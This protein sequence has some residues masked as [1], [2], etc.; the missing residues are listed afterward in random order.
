MRIA[1]IG[2]SEIVYD[3]G[4]LLLQ[5][6]HEIAL[7][8]T[9]KESPEYTRTAD[10]FRQLAERCGAM[11]IRTARIG[12]AVDRIRNLGPIDLAVSTNY[13]TLVP[14]DVIGCF[15]LGILNAHAGDLP[16][17][18]GNA[19]LAW[20]IL[21]GEVRVGLCVHYMDRELDAGDILARDYHPI[22]Q[23][24]SITELWDWTF[25]RTAELFVEAVERL[26][27]DPTFV[28]A[29]QSADPADALRGYPRRPSDGRIDW[30][31][32]ARDVVRLILASARPLP[33]AF[34]NV[35]S[36]PIIIWD[37]ELFETNERFLAVPG[38]VTRVGDGFVH[39]AAG[40]GRL[41]QINRVEQSEGEVTPDR[42]IRSIRSRLS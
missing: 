24:T 12:E 20:A 35:E 9:A 8:V 27:A 29:K 2:R 37:A 26:S 10:D 31:K 18:R 42:I 5:A 33:G 3:T 1:L 23:R 38:Q 40:D 14:Q 32:P 7:V 28:L 6:G 16:R 11:F 34:C 13:P 25:R 15:T 22:G 19:P 17:Y 41:V 4:E 39:V 21:Q 36:D 30:S